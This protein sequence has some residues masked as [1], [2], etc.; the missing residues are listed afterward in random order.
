MMMLLP[1]ANFT[2]QSP[3]KNNSQVKKSH[4]KEIRRLEMQQAYLL[5]EQERKRVKQIVEMNH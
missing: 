2:K 3:N 4:R 5:E 1:N